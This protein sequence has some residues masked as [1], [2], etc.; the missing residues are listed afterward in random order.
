MT[1]NVAQVFVDDDE[2]HPTL[3][4]IRASLR[5]GGRLVFETRDPPRRAWEE[6]TRAAT[7]QRVNVPG[8]GEVESWNDLNEV[9]LP[10]VSFRT[11]FVFHADVAVLT[12]GS[13]L[14]FRDRAEVGASFW[15][16]PG[17]SSR[18]SG[19]H[20]TGRA[21]RWSLSP[22]P[23]YRQPEPNRP[24]V[25]SVFTKIRPAQRGDHGP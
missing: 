10:L 25:A 7:W 11:S 22:R 8:V 14:T 6:W 12:S 24:V 1:G 23:S 20:Q 13:T 16:P 18:R 19:A 9:A 3:A 5:P 15:R 21:G 2:W 17:S 4:A